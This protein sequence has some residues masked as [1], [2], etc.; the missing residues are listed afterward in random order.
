MPPHLI[1]I[2]FFHFNVFYYYYYYLNSLPFRFLF[3]CLVL[4]LPPAKRIRHVIYQQILEDT[5]NSVLS[6]S[7]FLIDQTF[8]TNKTFSI[9]QM[10]VSTLEKR[11]EKCSL[12]SLITLSVVS[13]NFKARVEN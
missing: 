10:P 1:V 12:F 13:V 11:K 7:F 4:F 3:P 8:A 5:S 9:C 2:F 6:F